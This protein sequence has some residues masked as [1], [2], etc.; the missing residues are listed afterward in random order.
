M[1]GIEH[2]M[3]CDGVEFLGFRD[4]KF[5]TAR[6]SVH[7]LLPMCK[8][9]ASA[10]ALLPFLLS[11][12]SREYPDFTKLEQR[13]A[14]LYGASLSADVDKVGDMQVLSVAASGLADCYALEGEPVLQHL[15]DLLCSVLFDPLLED[16]LFPLDGFEQEKRQT[17]ELIETELNEKRSYARQRCESLMCAEEP[18]G[19]SRYGT[20]EEVA[21]LERPQLTESWKHV[22][23]HAPAR[24]IVMGNCELEPLY[25]RFCRAFR[26]L[27]RG[28][29][30]LCETHNRPAAP[31]V[32]EVK[33]ELPVAQ[34]KLVTGFRTGIFQPQ[35]EVAAMRMAMTIFGGTPSS[36][37]FVNV[38]EKQSLCYYCGASYNSMKG[39]VLVQSGVEEKNIE[40]ARAEI[41]KQLAE[42]QRGR[43]TEEEWSA[44]KLS[45]LNAYR[46]T[47]DSLGAL[48]GW[49]LT[50]SLSGRP[51]TLEEAAAE[52]EAVTREEIVAAANQLAL[53]TVYCLVGKGAAV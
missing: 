13:L 32:R 24:V 37:L 5:K 26:A 12:A 9:E 21:A 7:F 45:L 25:E 1:A 20:R 38:R 8:E 16:G 40:K 30:V 43:F 39:I 18:Y 52:M 34:A 29:L 19:L 50:Q 17:I 53:D 49:L 31:Q 10:N 22:V 28:A 41:L 33:E 51:L 2:R 48:S 35:K 15:A 6:M 44:A 11:R 3:I 23:A 46:T 36:K 47:A 14:E 27:S 4:P 42:L